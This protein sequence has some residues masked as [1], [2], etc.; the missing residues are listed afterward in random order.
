MFTKIQIYWNIARF[1]FIALFGYFYI[2]YT[3]G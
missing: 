3:V 2:Y 1:I